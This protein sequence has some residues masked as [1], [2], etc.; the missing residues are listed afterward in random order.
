MIQLGIDEVGR[1]AWAGPI[2][3]VAVGFLQPVNAT[4]FS[5]IF[6]RDSKL[7]SARQREK[8][9]AVLRKYALIYLQYLSSERIDSIGL[10]KGLAECI[11]LLVNKTI[12]GLPIGAEYK[13]W[14]DGKRACTLPIEHEF[15]IKGD[16]IMPI[17]SAASIIAKVERDAHMVSLAQVYP[18][19]GFEVHKGYGTAK[20]IAAIKKNGIC[21]AHRLS[22]RPI[23]ECLNYPQ[24]L[25]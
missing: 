23:G 24:H 14:I 8:A 13:F 20:H 17:I 12:K 7:L 2:V 3:F 5:K 10:S 15:I 18:Q 22:Y 9:D 25:V 11:E 4:D 19:Y 16:V 6:I 21:N 1:G